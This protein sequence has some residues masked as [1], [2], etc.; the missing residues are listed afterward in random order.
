MPP[1]RRSNIASFIAMDVLARANALEAEGRSVLHLEVGEPGSP[2]PA[3]V[4]EAARRALDAGRLGYTEALGREALRARIARHY[5]E[6]YGIDLDPA[7]VVVTT[8]SSGGFTLAFLALFD[9]GA[10]VGLAEPGYPAYRNILR[11]LDLVPVAVPVGAHNRWQV[12]PGDVDEAG[13]AARLDGLLVASPANPTGAMLAPD[14]LADLVDT[15]AR[16]D[17]TFISDEIY[18]GLTYGLE[19][20]TALRA[21]D[22]AIVINSFSKYYCMTG[23]RIGWMVVPPD[24][25]RVVERLAQNL[26]ISPPTISQIAAEAAFEAMAEYEALRRAYARNRDVLAAALAR[27]GLGEHAPADGAFYLYCDISR[28]SNHSADFAAR[29]LTETGVAATP[30]IDFDPVNGSS[31]LRFSYAS[32]PAVID[33]AAARLERWLG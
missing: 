20:A 21:S 8:G 9:A 19:A 33:E 32:D 14:A 7:R 10:R 1:S 13:R 3:V 25:V 17:V 24:L 26:Y 18:H 4:A 30:G 12:T 28:F 16:R 22:R 29:M 15:C 31:Y 2:A 27:A 11:A 6:R 5:G 23:W